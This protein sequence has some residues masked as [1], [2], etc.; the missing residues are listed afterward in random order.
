MYPKN[1]SIFK[2][3]FLSAQH[4]N[5]NILS[6]KSNPSHAWGTYAPMRASVFISKTLASHTNYIL[7]IT[8]LLRFTNLHII[9]Y[10]KPL[11]YYMFVYSK[12]V[13]LQLLPR[14]ITGHTKP[15]TRHHN[16][17][18]SN[19]IAIEDVTPPSKRTS[20]NPNKSYHKKSKNNNNIISLYR[21]LSQ[22][23]FWY[24]FSIM[25][26]IAY[27]AGIPPIS[28]STPLEELIATGYIASEAA[29]L[30][31]AIIFFST[32]TTKPL[33]HNAIRRH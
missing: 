23:E 19:E 11:S 30:C 4:K 6:N 24:G 18:H 2:S 28:L 15:N 8:R 29:K 16:T 12:S 9:L 20:P 14:I 13:C 21:D 25:E 1:T 33:A 26:T 5:L 17:S 22:M 27:Q 10:K 7:I 3:I 32:R 31:S